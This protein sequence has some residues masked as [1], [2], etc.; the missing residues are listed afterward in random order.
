MISGSAASNPPT[1]SMPGSDGSAM[2]NSV[3]ENAQ[4]IIFA[5]SVR[6]L[7][8]WIPL[9]FFKQEQTLAPRPAHTPVLQHLLFNSLGYCT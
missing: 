1:S 9:Y 5:G 4:T 3:A 8:A 7:L 6:P 2:E